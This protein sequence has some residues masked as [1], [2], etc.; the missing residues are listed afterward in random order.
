MSDAIALE[1]KLDI[2][3]VIAETFGVIRRNVASFL[4]LSL[5]LAGLPTMIIGLLQASMF[6]NQANLTFSTDQIASSVMSGLAALIVSAILQGALIY[7]TVQDLNGARP[8]IGASLANGLRAFLPLIGVSILFALGVMAGFVLLIVPGV[9]LITVWCV[10]VPALVA[11]NTGV[12]DAFRR[13][14]DLTRGNRWRV[15]ALLLIVWVATLI[16]SQIMLRMMGIGAIVRPG[17]VQAIWDRAFDPMSIAVKLIVNTL[18]SLLLAAGAAVLY[19]ELR[20]VRE[21]HGAEWLADI[22]G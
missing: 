3:R 7:A 22:F 17:D 6:R 9:I 4:V 21:G 18:T 11:E 5:L 20:K 2:G 13:S 12:V 16:I 15:F 19:V 8:T 10:A 14:A 1:R